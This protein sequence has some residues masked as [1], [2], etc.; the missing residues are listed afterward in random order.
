[1]DG[2]RVE[3]ARLVQV[4]GLYTVAG[5]R[6]DDCADRLRSLFHVLETQTVAGDVSAKLRS[7]IASAEDAARHSHSLGAQCAEIADAYERTERQVS[8][9]VAAL[10]ASGA[11]ASRRAA[12][13]IANSVFAVEPTRV[14]NS[15][16]PV[17]PVIFNGN[18]LPCEGWLLDRAIKAS[19]EGES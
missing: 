11:F 10:P 5:R 2:F 15:Y 18:Q 17:K 13:I 14:N 6:L 1:M 8:A 9:V 16:R 12:D 7:S 3:T 4:G 19:L